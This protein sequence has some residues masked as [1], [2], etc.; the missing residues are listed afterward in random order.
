MNGAF[1]LIVSGALAAGNSVLPYNLAVPV[2][3]YDA[4]VGVVGYEKITGGKRKG[5]DWIIKKV[6]PGSRGLTCSVLP[7]N[8]AVPINLYDAV[9]ETVRYKNIAG[10]KR[11]T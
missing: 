8:L 4:V 7:N 5:C 1:K 6:V 3:L 10:G 9:V 11:K 2:N